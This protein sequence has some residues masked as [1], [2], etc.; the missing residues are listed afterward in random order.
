MYQYYLELQAALHEFIKLLNFKSEILV[1]VFQSI[2]NINLS[3][4]NQPN[5]VVPCGSCHMY[6]YI[7]F[8]CQK[9]YSAF[10]CDK[11]CLKNHRQKHEE[12]CA[13]MTK[14]TPNTVKR[15]NLF[16]FYLHTVSR[17]LCKLKSTVEE[18]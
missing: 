17:I 15:V 12:E 16:D 9:C 4:E 8:H 3:K 6:I 14:Y 7:T 2:T 1:E 5:I 11:T 10:Y 13:G 18:I